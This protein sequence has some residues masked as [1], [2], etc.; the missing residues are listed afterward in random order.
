MI[1]DFCITGALSDGCWLGMTFMGQLFLTYDSHDCLLFNT[2][3]LQLW[4]SDVRINK[5][6][7]RIESLHYVPVLNIRLRQLS[8]D[9]DRNMIKDQAVLAVTVQLV[10][11]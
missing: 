2:V 8:D 9:D 5:L 1:M 7:L 6:R 3:A 10:V 11:Q 4:G